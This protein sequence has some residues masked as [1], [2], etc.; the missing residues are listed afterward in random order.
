MRALSIRRL[1]YGT[2]LVRNIMH[3]DDHASTFSTQFRARRAT[4]IACAGRRVDEPLRVVVFIAK[5]VMLV[6]T[7][8]D[9][10]SSLRRAA[11]ARSTQQGDQ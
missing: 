10:A 4:S 11:S 3:A 7:S 9:G 8:N 6:D 5:A 2:P 1:T